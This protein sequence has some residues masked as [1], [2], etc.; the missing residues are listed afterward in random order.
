MRYGTLAIAIGIGLASGPGLAQV[1]NPQIESYVVKT[2]AHE[3]ILVQE[4]V[5]EA[6]IGEVWGA[7][8]TSAGWMAWASPQAEVDLR[9]GGTIRTHYG[10]DAE[11]GDPGTN[12]LHIVN[13]VPERVLTLRAEISDRWPEVMKADE[14]KLMNVIV[15][16]ALGDAVTRIRSYGV[17]YRDLPAYDDL[18]EFFIPA[19]E[20]LFQKLKEHLEQAEPR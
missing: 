13:Y 16:D 10:P 18:M 2:D 7:Y 9:A 8:T 20:G 12:T 15:F 17:G 1:A 11:I 19:N 6:P 14:G 5:V 3:L 4:V